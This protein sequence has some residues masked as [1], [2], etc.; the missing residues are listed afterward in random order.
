MA[1]SQR[2]R[3]G[4]LL[5]GLVVAL[6]L[7]FV[8]SSANADGM[9]RSPIALAVAPGGERLL[10]ANQGA[11]TV[12]W[13]DPAGRRV[14]AEVATGDRPAGVAISPD[15]RIGFVSHWYGSD[16]AV[17]ELRPDGVAVLGRVA[18]GPEPRGVAIGSDSA[19]GYVA[20]GASNEVA[21]VDLKDQRVTGRVEVGREPRGLALTPD[22]TKLVVGN[23]RSKSLSVVDLA[24]FEVAATLPV[25]EDNLRQVAIGPDG[26]DAYVAA[27]LNRGMATT[28]NNIDLGWVLGQRIVRVPLDGRKPEGL[29][30][31]PLN[32]AVGDAHGMAVGRGGS[33]LAVACGGTH[34][35]L[36]FRQGDKP[37]PWRGGVGRDVMAA[38]LAR[39][40]ARF[41]RVK[42]G[43]RPTEL[44]FAPDGVTLY[45]ANYL[46]NAVDVINAE[47]GRKVGSIDLGGPSEPSLARRGEALFHDADRSTNHWYSCNTCHSDG[48][49]SGLNFDT[50]NDG[51]QD[52]SSN[53]LRSRKKVPTLRRTTLTGPWTWHGWQDSLDDS[54]VES[55]TKSMQGSAPKPDEVKALAAY[56]GT[57]DFPPNPHR[58]ADGGLTPEARRGEALFRSSRIGCASCHGSPEFNDTKVTDVGLLEVGD[59]YKGHNPPS[60]RGVYDKD[61]YLH[62]GRAKTLRDVLTGPHGPESLVGGEP[63]TPTEL[64]DLIAY[65]K[66]L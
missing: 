34:E 65:L 4:W 21:R 40:Q 38:D 55:F 23:A 35:V 54:I 15:G 14:V 62:D 51:W 59:V 9:D 48:H 43:G 16:V 52:L 42:L 1:N 36:L 28:R 3:R 31:D 22:G 64:D 11:G 30:L 8:P 24:R 57:L 7:G 29:S 49:T 19:T 66:S 61:P 63:L 27:M 53:H 56:L 10:V 20:L 25:S 2:L 12:S 58:A 41:R 50:R 39:D 33:L 44:A 32:D 17:L 13:V 5:G 45:A 37:L 46:A 47:A 6:G 60:L 26:K 18:V